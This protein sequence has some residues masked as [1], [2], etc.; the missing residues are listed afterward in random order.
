VAGRLDYLLR[1]AAVYGP[2]GASPLDFWHETPE[3]HP[4]LDPGKLGPYYMAFAGKAAYRGPFDADGVPLLDYRG[5]IGRRHNPIAVAQ[6]GLAIHNLWLK[7]RSDTDKA[8]FLRQAD[9]LVR[10]LETT[11]EGRKCWLHHF[12]FEYRGGLRAPWRSGL[13]Q[14]GGLSL[15]ARAH[16]AAKEARYQ[17]AM[18]EAFA[19][20]AAPVEKGG[21]LFREGEDSWIEEYI[22]DPPSHILNGFIWALW[23]VWDYHLSSESQQA[24]AVF[25]A[26]IATLLRNLKRFDSGWWSLYELGEPPM[27]A[28]AYYHRLHITQLRVLHRLTGHV[29]FKDTAERWQGYAASPVNRARSF[30]SK[31]VFKLLHY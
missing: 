20:L 10:N 5:K 25:E 18:D 6:Y 23:G 29:E 4:D 12:D 1:L 9:W 8:A 27:P 7:T 30:A 16:Q 31:A 14:G 24:K 17:T 11:Q 13:A 15:L 21:T 22:V 28:S 26:G 2:F 3:A 19:A